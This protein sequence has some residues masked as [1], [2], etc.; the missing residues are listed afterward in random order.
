MVD[1]LKR[2]APMAASAIADKL[3]VT[4]PAVRAQLDELEGRGLV[5]STTAPAAG[6]GR[7]ATL[8]SL[9]ELAL[10]LFPDR[11][12]DLTI[13]L[14]DA[15]RAASGEDG[16]A[17]VLAER[18]RRQLDEL[19][20]EM[21][22]ATS[23][24]ARTDVLAGHRSEQGYMAEVVEQG[25]DLL[26]VEHHCPVCDA[27]ATCQGLCSGELELFRSAM[28]DDVAVER[29]QHLLSGDQRCVYRIRPRS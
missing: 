29:T 25:D 26:L 20:T 13:E 21:S 12:S 6:R 23:I 7:P 24:R 17:K 19:R 9:T 11:H 27:A 1:C 10:D 22:N 2:G 18:D 5:T 15:I 4:G 28:G 8:W 16:L 14:L 3:G